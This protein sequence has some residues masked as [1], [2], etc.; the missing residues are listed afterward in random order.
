MNPI[1]TAY[2]SAKRGD[3]GAIVDLT[4]AILPTLG[5]GMHARRHIQRIVRNY[6][7]PVEKRVTDRSLMT[8]TGWNAKQ[9]ADYKAKVKAF[10]CEIRQSLP[11]AA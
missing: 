6:L 5:T 1:Q 11:M 4:S 8:G 2:I 7:L 10:M 9:L 3:D